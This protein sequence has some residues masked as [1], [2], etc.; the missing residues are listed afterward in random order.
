MIARMCQSATGRNKPSAFYAHEL[1]LD[2][3]DLAPLLI[4]KLSCLYVEHFPAPSSELDRHFSVTF[5]GSEVSSSS[6]V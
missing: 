3:F 5:Q 1:R 6:V 4:Q 2:P